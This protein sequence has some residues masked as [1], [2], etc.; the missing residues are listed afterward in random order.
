MYCSHC[1][2]RQKESRVKPVASLGTGNQQWVGFSHARR[3]NAAEQ[4]VC[5]AVLFLA[6][7]VAPFEDEKPQPMTSHKGATTA[8][9]HWQTLHWHMCIQAVSVRFKENFE[10]TPSETPYKA[11]HSALNYSHTCN[12]H[13]R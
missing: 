9:I 3:G 7:L 11:Y 13:Q 6:W 1:G 8:S 5:S 2:R 12:H 10:I 4:T